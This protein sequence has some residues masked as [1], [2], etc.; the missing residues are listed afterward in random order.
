MADIA[1]RVEKLRE[2]MKKEGIYAYYI[3]T[4]DFHSSEYVS[5]HFKVR[6]FFSG[7]TGSAGDLLI[8]EKEALLWTDGRYFIQAAKEL[9]GSGIKL[10]KSGEE[11]VP[12]IYGYLK[13][14]MPKK[15]ILGFDG[16]TVSAKKGKLFKKCVKK[17]A[18]KKDLT[19][20]IFKRPPFP[21]S[22]I[23]NLP[24]DL[25][26]MSAADKLGKIR[27]KLKNDG[28]EA[29][30]IS[31][32]DEIAYILNI[33]G[34][35]VAY[36]PLVMAYLYITDE[37]TYIFT[38]DGKADI[39]YYGII[40]KPYAE[41]DRFLLT[42]LKGKKVSADEES[43]SYLHYR[44]IKKRSKLTLK[45]SPVRMMKAVKNETEIL[46]LKDIYL[47]DSLALTRFIK[48]MDE[49]G[50][51]M[52][53][54][55]AAEKL[56]GFRKKIEE[57]RDLSFETISAYGENG[58]IIH[59]APKEGECASIGRKGF[60]MVDSGGQYMG[61]TTDVTRTL[62]MGELTDEE[63]EAFSLVAAGML[64][65]L[66]CVFMKGTYGVNIDILAR[67]EMWRRGI[68]YKHGT[69]H[70]VGY[71]LNVHEGPQAIRLKSI[72][73]DA[74]FEPGMLVSDEPGIYKKGKFGVRTENILL[75]REE[76]KTGD[77]IFYSFESLTM[78]PID[79][80]GMD[81]RYL[82]DRQIRNYEKYQR[83]VFDSLSPFLDEGER[84][85][86]MNYSGIHN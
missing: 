15:G 60:Y 59:Y 33:R 12:D 6:E 14:E 34:K 81:M 75:V 3:P 78:V 58:A 72:S 10:M 5:D 56:L 22:K 44:M 38:G 35:D 52:T 68:D 46:H 49:N 48:W 51:E 21:S 77:G 31:A 1:K 26:G 28:L 18:Y 23:E 40:V 69:G 27:E 2:V 80:R 61:G 50:T 64:D 8:T 55:S 65:I 57:F 82:S 42:S 24:D 17:L 11:G 29:I 76:N 74:A 70:G 19:N 53:E 54:I 45:T 30:F 85:W 43:I 63:K 67:G 20:G 73:G 37:K 36:N 13:K 4:S 83:D 84:N 7:F 47:K 16:R 41:V 66:N 79:H 25:T 9:E 32:L 62:V 86:L 71:M 39:S